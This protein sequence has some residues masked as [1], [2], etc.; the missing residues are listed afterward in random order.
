MNVPVRGRTSRSAATRRVEACGAKASQSPMAG[1]SVR[2][3]MP[4][5]KA[6]WMTTWVMPSPGAR[7]GH[8]PKLTTRP[9]TSPSAARGAKVAARSADQPRSLRLASFTVLEAAASARRCLEGRRV[10]R[11]VARCDHAGHGSAPEPDCLN[12]PSGMSDEIR[13]WSA[14]QTVPNPVAF[15]MP[16]AEL[17]VWSKA[18]FPSWSRRE[19]SMRSWQRCYGCWPKAASRWWPAVAPAWRIALRWLRPCCPLRHRGPGRCSDA[20]DEVPSTEQLAAMMRSGVGLGLTLDARDLRTVMS[21]LERQPGG[22]PED[23]IRRLGVVMVVEQT[24]AGLRSPA[25][26][27]LR[28]AERDAQGHVQRRP[29][30]VLATWDASADSYE[31]SRLGHHARAGRSRRP[32]PGGLRGA[33]AQPSFVHRGLGPGL[34]VSP[35]ALEG[36]RR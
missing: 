35:R 31:H 33:A 17:R 19:P 9:A 34:R 27:Y 16:V 5:L 6:R 14:V 24:E 7:H 15:A 25:V 12:P 3:A 21:R 2:S 13:T 18:H 30:A 4:R 29:P 10:Q 32:L 36:Q 26:H 11:S 23:A 1:S 20:D 8:P 28:Q 22:L